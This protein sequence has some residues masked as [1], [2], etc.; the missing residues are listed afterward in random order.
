MG[1]KTITITDL[2]LAATLTAIGY[3]LIDLDRTNSKRVA[4]IFEYNEKIKQSINDYWNNEIKLSALT[5]FN[6]QKLLKNRLYS[7]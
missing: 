5:L 2:N 7:A 1:I 4:F 6:A 3:K